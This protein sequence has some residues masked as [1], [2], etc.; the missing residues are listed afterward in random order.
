MLSIIYPYRNRELQRIKNSLDS[1]KVQTN[2]QFEVYFVNYG[3][4]LQ[5]SMQIE[6]LCKEY[7]W[8]TYL[9]HSTQFQPWNKSRALNSVIKNLNTD[10]CFVA[11]VDMIFHPEFVCTAIELQE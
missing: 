3:S 6:K 11:D 1:L 10:F 9:L 8:V 7:E 5:H 2:K 4:E